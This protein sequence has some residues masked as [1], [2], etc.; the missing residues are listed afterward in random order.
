MSVLGYTSNLVENKLI[1]MTEEK[2]KRLW[3]SPWGYP[4]SVLVVIAIILSGYALQINLDCLDF[5]YLRWPLNGIIAGS[6]VAVIIILS[7][8]KTNAF[9]N[10]FS[11]VSFSVSLLAGLLLLTVFMGLT[12]QVDAKQA[13]P[14]SVISILGLD[15]MTRSWPFVLLYLSIL[16]SLGVLVVRSLRAFE[17]RRYAFY[18]NHLGLWL[19]LFTAGFAASDIRRYVMYVQV[20]D[21]MPEWRVYNEKEEV[22]ELPIAIYLNEFV[23]D[24]YPPKLT[25]INRK[26]GKSLPL[27]LPQYFQIDSLQ[28]KGELMEWQLEM[29]NFIPAAVRNTKDTYLSMPMPGS[30]AAAQVRLTNKLSKQQKTAWVSAGSFAQNI[31]KIDLD[32]TRALVMTSPEPKRFASHV[33]VYSEFLEKPDTAVIEVNKPLEHGDWIIYQYSYDEKMGKAS[34]FSS[35]ELVYDPWKK[36]VY[37]SFAM[38]ALG[39]IALF[40]Q[41]NS[42]KK[43]GMKND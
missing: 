37:F 13:V 31:A 23:L 14:H 18:L 35:F 40:W 7:F 43:E 42:K 19:L 26:T 4:E 11:G 30:C 41:L 2:K 17:L 29:L 28:T 10:W 34:S 1:I 3:A 16:L 38:L 21:D 33:V 24:E 32:S 22:L 12:Q 6:I 20:K 27:D 15:R 36:Y 25:I 5:F 9:V 8:I 39:S